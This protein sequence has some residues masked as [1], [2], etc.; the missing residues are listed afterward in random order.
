MDPIKQKDPGCLSAQEAVAFNAQMEK[1]F[2][3]HREL[4]G[5]RNFTCWNHTP[6]P[7]E[8]DRY[9][10]NYANIKW[11]NSSSDVK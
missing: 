3:S 8:N 9:R 2:R 5:K 10:R 6:T 7:G 4:P 1:H 11:D